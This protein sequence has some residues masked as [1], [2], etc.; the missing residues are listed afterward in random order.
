LDASDLAEFTPQWVAPL[1]H[2]YRGT[3]VFELPAPTQGV[4]ALEA[5]A[6]LERGDPTFREQVRCAALALEDGVAKVRDRVDVRGLLEPNFITTRFTQRPRAVSEPGGSTVYVAAVD[7]GGMCVSLIQSLFHAFGSRVIAGDTGVVLQ[8]RVA[9]FVIDGT[10][11]PGRRPFH[12]II[13]GLLADADGLLGPFGVVGGSIQ[14]QGHMQL[15]S[16]IV[17]DRLDPQAVLERPRFRIEGDEVLLEGE[18][19]RRAHELS[20]LGVRPQRVRDYKQ[21]GGGQMILRDSARGGWLGGSDPRKDGRA[22][23]F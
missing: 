7:G 21:F 14:A 4:V 11:A 12:T 18:L 9:G 8:N 15:V 23:G 20:G 2:S 19:W 3:T 5:L 10:V 1:A 22:S 13:P 16:G 6:L 17:D